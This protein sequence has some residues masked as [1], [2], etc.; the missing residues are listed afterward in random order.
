MRHK[1]PLKIRQLLPLSI[2][3]LVVL[4]AIGGPFF[5]PLALPAAGW[6]FGCVS[7]GLLLGIRARNA[8][9]AM[10]GFAA[11]IMHFSWSAG[12]LQ[13]RLLKPAPGPSP[14]PISQG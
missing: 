2:A 12:F 1:T 7:F 10:A 5:W 6:A 11:M 13:Q 4:A 3:P 14:S 8:C 9:A